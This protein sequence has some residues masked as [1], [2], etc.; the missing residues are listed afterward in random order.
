ME[1]YKTGADDKNPGSSVNPPTQ[2]YAGTY[3]SQY[4][5]KKEIIDNEIKT[6]LKDP[7]YKIYSLRKLSKLVRKGAEA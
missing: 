3:R 2:T 6:I 7:R 1:E 5:K 4:K